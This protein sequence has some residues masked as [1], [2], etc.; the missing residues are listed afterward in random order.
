MV[1]FAILDGTSGLAFRPG[2]TGM[3]LATLCSLLLTDGSTCAFVEG[4]ARESFGDE[5]KVEGCGIR[6]TLGDDGNGR[7]LVRGGSNVEAIV[8]KIERDERAVSPRSK[9]NHVVQAASTQGKKAEGKNP[10]LLCRRFLLL[11]CPF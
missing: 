8:R 4:T 10:C 5:A 1:G 6:D 2:V 9:V 3:V 7:R 11:Y